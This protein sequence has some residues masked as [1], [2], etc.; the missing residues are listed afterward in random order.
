MSLGDSS[1]DEY[2]GKRTLDSVIQLIL[3]P[4]EDNNEGEEKVYSL[5]ELKDLQSKLMLIAG[6]APKGKLEDVQRFVEVRQKSN[7]LLFL[8][9]FKVFLIASWK[10]TLVSQ[11][12]FGI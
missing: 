6:K 8:L 1:G 3:P 2:R 12:W 4:E 9:F 7:L 5:D 10:P 11:H